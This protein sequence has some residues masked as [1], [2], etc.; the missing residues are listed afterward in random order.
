V[1]LAESV[2][3]D[4]LR[5]ELSDSIESTRRVEWDKREGR[6]VSIL[7]EKL[8]AL[9]LSARA[10]PRRRKKWLSSSV[11]Q[12]GRGLPG[13]FSAEKPANSRDG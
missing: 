10:F 6:I 2:S 3:E 1:H 12:S 9:R 11:K 5:E 8:G 13:S 7:E 4:L